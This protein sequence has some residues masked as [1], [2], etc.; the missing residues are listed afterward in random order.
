MAGIDP[1]WADQIILPVL[2]GAQQALHPARV[3][4]LD[5]LVEDGRHPERHGE[6]HGEKHGKKEEL[7]GN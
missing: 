1:P 3:T 5:G 2:G 4:R 6:K 7:M